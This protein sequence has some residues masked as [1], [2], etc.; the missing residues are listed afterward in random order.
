[1]CVA[2]VFNVLYHFSSPLGSIVVFFHNLGNIFPSIDFHRFRGG[3][4]YRFWCLFDTFFVRAYNRQNLQKRWQLQW[5]CMLLHIRRTWCLM[6]PMILFA[7]CFALF[8][9]PPQPGWVD[10]RVSL[11]KRQLLTA[12]S[13]IHIYIYLYVYKY[14]YIYIYTRTHP[15]YS[16]NSSF[17]I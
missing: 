6:I 3:V 5:I 12:S 15:D 10:E 16:H 1:M 11:K 2:C 7:T 9:D 8:F 4:R 13:Y 17:G 14:I